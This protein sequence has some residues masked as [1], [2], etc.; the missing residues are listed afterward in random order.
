MLCPPRCEHPRERRLCIFELL[1][2]PLS[3]HQIQLDLV[4]LPPGAEAQ[5]LKYVMTSVKEGDS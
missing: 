3:V 4:P 5:N 2:Q 1:Q